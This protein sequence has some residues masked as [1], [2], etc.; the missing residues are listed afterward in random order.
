M[1][2]I[3]QQ[4]GNI[5][6]AG[7]HAQLITDVGILTNRPDLTAEI[8][9]AVR[10]ATIK[11]HQA[12]FWLGDL[13][14]VPQYA[15]PAPTVDTAQITSRYTIN[16]VDSVNFPRLRKVAYIRPYVA[17]NGTVAAA[18]G[19]E[20]L[21]A[22]YGVPNGA[23]NYSEKSAALIMDS[24]GVESTNYW[25]QAGMQVLLRINAPIAYVV[26][27]Y[28]NTPDVTEVNYNSWIAAQFPHLIVE[29]AASQVFRMIGKLDESA[30]YG[31]AW[32]ENLHQLMMS[33]INSGV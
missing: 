25:Y 31:K 3:A 7:V 11:A 27:G 18:S 5:Q 29:E 15:L 24:Y 17:P 12:D 21:V 32:G 16:L 4:S 19:W 10:K 8:G 6:Y 22:N 9:L 20:T 13:Q 1:S 23:R 28:Y 2:I 26:I 33:Q 30:A 14:V